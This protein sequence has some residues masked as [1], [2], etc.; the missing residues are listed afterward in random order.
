MWKACIIKLDG[1]SLT[2]YQIGGSIGA[3][4]L[5]VP[6]TAGGDFNIIPD[7]H[8]NTMYFGAT[9]ATGFGT[10]GGELHFM[11]GETT[12]FSK[13]RFNIYDAA[14]SVYTKIMGW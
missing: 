5:G 8:L 6:L 9:T 11:Q 14:S 10:P 3:P 4:L 7:R 1:V 13:K 2:G 12:A